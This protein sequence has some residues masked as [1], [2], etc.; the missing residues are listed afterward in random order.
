[1]R[2]T[3]IVGDSGRESHTLPDLGE[4]LPIRQEP[5]Q[6]AV[7]E[8]EPSSEVSGARTLVFSSN[9]SP[10]NAEATAQT[11]S[12][13]AGISS[14]GGE[15]SGGVETT[16][17]AGSRAEHSGP[18]GIIEPPRTT[19]PVDAE[20]SEV[21][22]PA[23][24]SRAREP[25]S[26]NSGTADFGSGASVPLIPGSDANVPSIDTQVIK[27]ET[28]AKSESLDTTRAWKPSPPSQGLPMPTTGSL[29]VHYQSVMATAQTEA[30]VSTQA[31]PAPSRKRSNTAIIS[32]VVA[33]LVLAL[34]G[35][36]VW[37]FVSGGA[38]KQTPPRV[39]VKP[40][41]AETVAPPAPPA[42]PPAPDGMVLVPAGNYIIGRNDGD[43]LERPQ[44]S[45]ELKPFYIDRTEVTN[46]DYKKFVDQ[47]G[48]AA[49]L[50]W[51]DGN[52]PAGRDLWP[53]VN[54]SWQDAVDYATWSGKRLPTEEEWEAAARGSE[55]RVYPWGDRWNR[56][57][58]NI[59]SKSISDVGQHAD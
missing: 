20:A 57:L 22:P 25:I 30:P 42:P 48:H 55:G 15:R 27:Q 28:A 7:Q 58:A 17:L 14:F 38:R 49:P 33:F 59:D 26:G 56:N 18:T 12:P 44:Y 37:W 35:Y 9:D 5:V 34:A 40:P 4:R 13:E 16:V 47:T 45:V 36:F 53:V 50:G 10:E 3:E 1:M 41:P 11:N 19:G 43:E 6:E 52:Y 39:E 29:G 8:A 46:A 24:G 31:A 2:P 23:D 32:L 54:V 51:T 21:T